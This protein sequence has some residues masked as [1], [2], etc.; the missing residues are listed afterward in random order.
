MKKLVELHAAL[1]STYYAIVFSSVPD[2]NTIIEFEEFLE[3]TFF[4]MKAGA[5]NIGTF[6]SGMFSGLTDDQIS[7]S[8]MVD[9]KSSDHFYN[10]DFGG[11]WILFDY[12]KKEYIDWAES[13]DKEGDESEEFKV[14]KAFSYKDSFTTALF[15]KGITEE[16]LER[17]FIFKILNYEPDIPYTLPDNITKCLESENLTF[18]YSKV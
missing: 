15:S 13:L 16:E 1:N 9:Y 14:R 12:M 3:K 17:V 10:E 5:G 11:P 18:L 7:G 2:K 6:T 4:Q 8:S